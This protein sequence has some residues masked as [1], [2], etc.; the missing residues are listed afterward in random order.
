MRY[1]FPRTSNAEKYVGGKFQVLKDGNW[2]NTLFEI[3][4]V[5]MEG[6]NSWDRFTEEEKSGA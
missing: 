3:L 4:K 6:W 5:P 1:F 2:D